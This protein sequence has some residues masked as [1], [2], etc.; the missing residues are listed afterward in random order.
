[1]IETDIIIPMFFNE[2]YAIK[3][4]PIQKEGAGFQS[5]KDQYVIQRLIQS[6]KKFI[7]ILDDFSASLSEV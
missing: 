1:M 5:F 7:F 6:L 2:K 4:P 3:N